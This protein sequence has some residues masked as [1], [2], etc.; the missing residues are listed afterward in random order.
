MLSNIMFRWVGLSIFAYKKRSRGVML[1]ASFCLVA[2]FAAKPAL[3]G[4]ERG[5]ETRKAELQ[6]QRN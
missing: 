4:F 3:E 5:F 6:E 2:A 1:L